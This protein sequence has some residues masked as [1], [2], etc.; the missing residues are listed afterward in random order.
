MVD[1]IISQI[2]THHNHTAEGTQ[3]LA[4]ELLPHLNATI[5]ILPKGYAPHFPASAPIKA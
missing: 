3:E 1:F 2:S 5:V 4:Y